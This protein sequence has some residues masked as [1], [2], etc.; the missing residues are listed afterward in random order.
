MSVHA[1]RTNEASAWSIALTKFME[2][3]YSS[4]IDIGLDGHKTPQT[5]GDLKVSLQFKL[6]A[7]GTL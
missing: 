5:C 1:T 6:F 4:E 7:V 2:L 3:S